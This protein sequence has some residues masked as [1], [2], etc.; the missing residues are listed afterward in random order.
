[1]GEAVASDDGNDKQTAASSSSG[2]TVSGPLDEKQFE[3]DLLADPAFSE[4]KMK[5]VVHLPHIMF[6]RDVKKVI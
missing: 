5:L 4:P 1:L 2:D 3:K 6:V